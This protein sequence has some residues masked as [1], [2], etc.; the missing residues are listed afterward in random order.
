MTTGMSSPWRKRA[1]VD[2][3]ITIVGLRRTIINI[4]STKED[5]KIIQ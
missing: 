5:V 3:V 1:T 2:D 4:K